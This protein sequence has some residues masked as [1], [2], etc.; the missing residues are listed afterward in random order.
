MWIVAS[1]FKY[2]FIPSISIPQ[3]AWV[4]TFLYHIFAVLRECYEDFL[5]SH[6]Q[7]AFALHEKWS[8]HYR[9]LQ[10]MWPGDCGFDH[11]YWR[12][13]QWKTLIC[14]T[15]LL[16]WKQQW[17]HYTISWNLFKL[18]FR[19]QSNVSSVWKGL[20]LNYKVLIP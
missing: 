14:C 17:K 5:E 11:F 20:K 16:L 7:P 9:Y 4:Q 6:L 12:N 13:T 8:F 3:K 18:T 1:K 2:E 19:H 10:Y 15:M